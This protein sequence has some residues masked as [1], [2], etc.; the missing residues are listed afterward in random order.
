MGQSKTGRFY[1]DVPASELQQLLDFR[2]RYP[3]RV[4]EIQGTPWRYIDS[5]GDGPVV[6]VLAGGTS[7][8][9]TSFQTLEHL[10]RRYHVIAPDYPPVGKI[11]ALFAGATGLLDH[12]GVGQF[13]LVG[14]SYGGWMAQSFVRYCPDRVK[15]LVLTASGPP[16]PE[17]SRQIEKMLPLLRL[18]PTALLRK[19]LLRTFT[20]LVKSDQ[21]NQQFLLAHLKEI[22]YEH[23][24]RADFLSSMQR[25]VDQT[26]NYT[27]SPDDLK[28]W[29]GQILL[30]SGS[31]D[32]AATPEKRA[33]MLVLYPQTKMH[34]IQ[35]ADH[36][37]SLT[38]QQEYFEVIDTFLA[39]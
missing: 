15:K 8:A 38:H 39:G 1:A 17:N 37:A 18:L 6:F 34:V 20:N 11:D 28:T 36:S 35:G 10:A 33:A 4:A 24:H 29:P 2:A 3:Y 22:L 32:P 19:M 27:F 13:S 9:E 16:D 12:L 31:D 23:V 30:L 7:I 5:G 14:G 25:L 26:R 21:P